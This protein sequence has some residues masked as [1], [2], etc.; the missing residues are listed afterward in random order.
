MLE[1]GVHVCRIG[2]AI[3]QSLDLEI[4]P[5]EMQQP[6]PELTHPSLYT[7]VKR[8]QP[9]PA[10]SWVDPPHVCKGLVLLHIPFPVLPKLLLSATHLV[11]L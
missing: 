8:R 11:D 10:R 6:S 5:A 9:F 1:R 3:V 4:I 2:L 7:R